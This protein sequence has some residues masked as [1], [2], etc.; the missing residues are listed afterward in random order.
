MLFYILKTT[1]GKFVLKIFE[2]A[3]IDYINYQIKLMNIAIKINL[4]IEV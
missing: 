2:R 3:K 1:K 4:L